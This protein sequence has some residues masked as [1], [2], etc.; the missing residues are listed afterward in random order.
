MFDGFMQEGQ[1][2]LASCIYCGA[3][4]ATTDPLAYCICAEC[5]KGG[6]SPSRQ[7]WEDVDPWDEQF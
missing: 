4:I 7:D 3:K 1:I 2:Q 6:N 5:L